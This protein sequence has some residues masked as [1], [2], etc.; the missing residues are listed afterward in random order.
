MHQL[1]VG[2]SGS[3]VKNSNT[4]RLV[5][6]VLRSTG[7]ETVFIKLSS[8]QVQPCRACLGCVDDNVC[9]VKDDFQEIADLVRRAGALVVGG[10]P[11]YGSLDGFTKSFLERL[12]SLRHRHARNRGKLAV[13]VVTGNGRGTPGIDVASSQLKTALSHEGMEVIGQLKVTGNIKCTACG[14][15]TTCP[16]SALS[17]IFDGNPESAP[18]TYCKVEDQLETWNNATRLGRELALRL[19]AC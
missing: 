10:Y 18:T 6:E 2:I 7:L 3:P 19:A 15:L 9:K 11:P 17:R 12:F 5:Q 8:R 1:V 14:H 16:M 4:D 13:T